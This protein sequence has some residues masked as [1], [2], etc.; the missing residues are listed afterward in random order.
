VSAPKK[1]PR[2]KANTPADS[3][4]ALPSFATLR[5]PTPQEALA[6]EAARQRHAKRKG[7]VSVNHTRKGADIE[8]SNPH[9]DGSGW[10]VALQEVFASASEDFANFNI[11][12]LQNLLQA[13]GGGVIPINAALAF[14][15]GIA[16][17]SELEAG[18]AMQIAGAHFASLQMTRKAMANS[19]EGYLEAAAAYTG[20]A[21]KFS[22][23]MVAHVEALTKLRG[24]GRQIVEHRYI[25]VNAAN[26]I[27]G[28]G[29]QAVF[30]GVNQTPGGNPEN[31]HR[32]HASAVEYQPGAP[33]A[34]VWGQDP[35]GVVVPGAC[36]DGEATLPHARGR[37]SGRPDGT[38]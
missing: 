10:S 12:A 8:I 33:V 32:P 5:D 22:R 17:T 28:D 38:S 1:P 30:G 21:T 23:T 34:P 14:I 16:P 9:T 37:K 24:G 6:I 13:M 31:A 15:E 18:M 36:D 29:T 7:R 4:A 25:N 27:V 20:M 2:G 26:A 11:N 19:A 35:Q 3:A